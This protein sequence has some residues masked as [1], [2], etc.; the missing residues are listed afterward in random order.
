MKTYRLNSIVLGTALVL[1]AAGIS[2]AEPSPDLMNSI[3]RLR[4]EAQRNAKADVATSKPASAGV[5]YWSWSRTRSI[6]A[7]QSS[8]AVPDLS[9]QV[10]AEGTPGDF[11]V[12]PLQQL[13][14]TPETK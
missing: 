12:A 3:H 10:V 1:T 6:T 7:G 5:T 8:V 4:L 11:K 2:R 9:H 13:N 14:S